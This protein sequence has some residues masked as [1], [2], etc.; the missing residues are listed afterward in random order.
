MLGEYQFVPEFFLLA[1]VVGFFVSLVVVDGCC[2][3]LRE[4]EVVEAKPSSDGLRR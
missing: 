1:I 3:S 2:E 4:S